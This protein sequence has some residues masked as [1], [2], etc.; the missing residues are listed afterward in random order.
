MGEGR[1]GFVLCL[2][3]RKKN[4]TA[5]IGTN[6]RPSP[7]RARVRGGRVPAFVHPRHIP[8]SPRPNN[9]NFVTLPAAAPRP[10]LLLGAAAGAAAAALRARAGASS[11]GRRRTCG[12]GGS[13]SAS[14]SGSGGGRSSSARRRCPL[15]AAAGGHAAAA[16][17]ARAAAGAAAAALRARAAAAAPLPAPGEEFRVLFLFHGVLCTA[18]EEAPPSDVTRGEARHWM[19]RG[20]GECRRLCF[21]IGQYYF[22]PVPTKR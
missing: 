5:C 7:S 21:S 11:C 20:G 10:A 17:R 3:R 12:G 4:R 6:A 13:S 22:E 2:G 9:A 16:L 8:P 14:G 1:G 15:L 18:R 19:E